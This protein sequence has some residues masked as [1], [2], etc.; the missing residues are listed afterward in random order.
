MSEALILYTREQ[1]SL[2]EAAAAIVAAAGVAVRPV[3]IGGDI[4]LLMR[5][6]DSIPVI[7]DPASEAEIGWPFNDAD[8][9]DFCARCRTPV[10]TQGAT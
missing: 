10:G 1:C 5:Y 3:D 4:E 7:R 2:C 9:I 6:R 8:L